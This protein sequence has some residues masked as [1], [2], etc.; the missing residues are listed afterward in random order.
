MPTIKINP[1]KPFWSGFTAFVSSMASL[2]GLNAVNV[3]TQIEVHVNWGGAIV[4]SLIISLVVY[5]K[6]KIA[7]SAQ[8]S[9]TDR[10]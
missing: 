4:A 7:S 8:Q 6:E 3:A 1:G 9:K 2:L 5:G 10:D